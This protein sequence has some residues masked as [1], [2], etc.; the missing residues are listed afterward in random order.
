MSCA[1][2]LVFEAVTKI[3]AVLQKAVYCEACNSGGQDTVS[4]CFF[5]CSLQI[6]RGS[7][8]QKTLKM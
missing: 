3:L 8:R 5:H 2:A 6:Y 4:R 1:A 7:F